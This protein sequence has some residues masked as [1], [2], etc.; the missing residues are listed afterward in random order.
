MNARWS[1]I[2]LLLGPIISPAVHAQAVIA[3]EV[4]QA[5]YLV[6]EAGQ[7]KATSGNE[8]LMASP[9]KGSDRVAGAPQPSAEAAGPDP[10]DCSSGNCASLRSASYG[11]PG[12]RVPAVPADAADPQSQFA[13]PKAAENSIA[14][15][16]LGLML[17]FAF[18]L[19][20]YP[21][22]RRQRALRRSLVFTSYIQGTG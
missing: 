18:G 13:D 6:F 22:V 3:T 17:L 19:L 7:S 2:A 1:L 8:R 9:P 21:L 20:A 5:P 4:D 15:M 11:G 16:D 10:R 14:L 12:V